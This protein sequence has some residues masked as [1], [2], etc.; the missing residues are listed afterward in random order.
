MDDRSIDLQFVLNE[1]QYVVKEAGEFIRSQ[2]KKFKQGDIEEKSANSLVTYVDKTAE[3]ILVSGLAALL[4]E[5]GFVT[6]ENT[7]T[8][9]NQYFTWVIDPLDG[10][11]NFLYDIPIFS[12]SV[13]LLKDGVP[14]LG[15]VYEIV[16]DELFTAIAGLG[17]YLNG[18]PIKVTNEKETKNVV[19][20]TGFPYEKE[21]LTKAHFSSLELILSQT[22]GIRRLGSAAVDLC[23]VACGR[24]GVYYELDLNPWDVAAGGLIVEEAGGIVTALKGQQSWLTGK[25][26]LAYAPNLKEG[27]FQLLVDFRNHSS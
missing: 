21:N 26:I 25:N 2:R 14:V 24:F 19:F 12:V 1:T 16:Q 22:R 6:E 23:Y 4:P 3:K 11:T 9:S 8:Q 10:T 5:S 20:A 7:T 15:I 13:A 27:V 17:A 18:N